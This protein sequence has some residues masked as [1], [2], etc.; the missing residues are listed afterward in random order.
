VLWTLSVSVYRG[1]NRTQEIGE[2]TGAVKAFAKELDIPI[3][4]LSQLSRAPEMREDKRPQLSDLRDSGSIEQDADVVMFV[5]RE[6]YYLKRHAPDPRSDKEYQSWQARLAASHGKAEL[7]VAK[8]RNGPT[9]TVPLVFDDPTMTFRSP[10]DG[11]RECA[12]K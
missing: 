12:G 9:G 11:G 2:I 7:I 10:S 8:L 1:N 4:L 3:M 5:Y 6:G